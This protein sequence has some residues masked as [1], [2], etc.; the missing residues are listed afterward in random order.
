MLDSV[1]DLVKLEYLFIVHSPYLQVQP[2]R[3]TS[4]IF[5]SHVS[6]TAS[7]EASGVNENYDKTEER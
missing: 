1:I 6:S 2:S 7:L 5:A 3:R 4:H